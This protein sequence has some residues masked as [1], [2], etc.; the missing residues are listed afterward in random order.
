[1]TENEQ[2]QQIH[3]EKME[4]KD[5]ILTNPAFVRFA[6]GFELYQNLLHA[7]GDEDNRS[8]ITKRMVELYASRFNGS[9]DEERP[10]ATKQELYK[11]ISLVLRECQENNFSKDSLAEKIA[12]SS[13]VNLF[14]S[15]WNRKE[16]E[17]EE[18]SGMIHVND[19]I[20]YKQDNDDEISLHIRPTGIGSSELFPKVID[21]FQIIGGKL[22][23][24]EIKASRII[25]KSWLLNSQMEKKARLILGD[26]I[27][28]IDSPTDDSDVEAVQ[29]LA[30][31]YNRKSLEKYLKTGEKPEVR[32]VIMTRDEF[33]LRFK[34][35]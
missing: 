15:E 5:K 17:I 33:I 12:S 6:G 16:D 14:L 8:A 13:I 35:V 34:K 25:M 9:E 2:L 18:G 32:Q 23:A 19:A 28:I 20:A 10:S 24:E 22:E 27:S 21:G 31:Q 4:T 1:M 7:E 30:L 11:I 29:Y 3:Q 26:E